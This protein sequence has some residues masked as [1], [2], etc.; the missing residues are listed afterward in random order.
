MAPPPTLDHL[1]HYL[2]P[3][4]DIPRTATE[5]RQ[6]L[7]ALMNTRPLQEETA[8]FCSARSVVIAR[9][10]IYSLLCKLAVDVGINPISYR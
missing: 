10:T 5:K 3:T 1:I 8:F 2:E 7:R 4:I 6:L 9:R